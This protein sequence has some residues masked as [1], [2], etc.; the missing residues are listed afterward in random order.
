MTRDWDAYDATWVP[1]D[2]QVQACANSLRRI[3]EEL[4][5]TRSVPVRDVIRDMQKVSQLRSR[6][7]G[8]SQLDKIDRDEL[9]ARLTV[10]FRALQFLR[11]WADRFVPLSAETV[12]R[13]QGSRALAG[14]PEEI[15]LSCRE[16]TELLLLARPEG[17]QFWDLAR[18][19]LADIEAELQ[20][21]DSAS[22]VELIQYKSTIQWVAPAWIFKDRTKYG[23][24]TKYGYR[25]VPVNSVVS[26]G[27]PGL[28]R[29]S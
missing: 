27:L 1:L 2:G 26:G 15:L 13:I 6:A 20:N 16:R 17:R 23:E 22:A 25:A 3:L 14:T 29:S 7:K 4:R 18:T 19:L 28:G 12:H 8:T 5:R 9:V 21:A 11:A 10:N 24:S